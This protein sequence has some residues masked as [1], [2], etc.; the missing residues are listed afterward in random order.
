MTF[1]TPPM[2]FPS[3]PTG[4]ITMTAT[5]AVDETPPIQ[6][7]FEEVTGNPGATDSLWQNSVTFLDGA[8]TANTP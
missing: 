6:Y 4:A 7:Q 1:A 8:L 2:P 5:T 3:V